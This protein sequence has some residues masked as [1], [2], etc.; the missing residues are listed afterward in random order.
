MEKNITKIDKRVPINVRFLYLFDF[1]TLNK[2]GTE[3]KSKFYIK[4]ILF[5]KCTFFKFFC[6]FLF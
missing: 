3:N 4:S 1:P 2:N 5:Y 6:F